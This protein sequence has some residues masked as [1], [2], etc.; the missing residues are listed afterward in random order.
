MDSPKAELKPEYIAKNYR[1]LNADQIGI[2][3]ATP[4]LIPHL[5]SVIPKFNETQMKATIPILSCEQIRTTIPKLQLQQT[6]TAIQVMNPAQ[7]RQTIT[8]LTA[9]DKNL[10]QQNIILLQTST[11]KDELQ[12]FLNFVDPLA[13]AFAIKNP[14]LTKRILEVAAIMTV[15]QLRVVLPLLSDE[16]VMEAFLNL[17]ENQM[18]IA[19]SMIMEKKVSLLEKVAKNFNSLQK[20]KDEIK[21]RL[22]STQDQT[23]H[24]EKRITNLE[25]ADNKDDEYQTIVKSIKTTKTEVEG[26]QKNMRDIQAAFKLPF[27]ILSQEQN[28]DIYEKYHKLS[29]EISQMARN[30]HSFLSRLSSNDGLTSS[31][32][33]IW[34]RVQPPKIRRD[35]STE[36]IP[37]TESESL[38]LDDNLAI[39]LYDAVKQ[40]GNPD[41]IG[42]WY[43]M[44]WNDIISAGFR[45]VQDFREKGVTSLELLQQYINSLKAKA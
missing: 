13:M 30:G 41:A 43:S 42:S 11:N 10:L 18:E 38:F 39:V 21:P 14:D 32:N 20:L 24:L 33:D 15:D 1:K 40:I 29:N 3:L 22:E 19:A 44:T 36:N 34:Q 31:L 37:E 25:I 27:R 17:D 6:G 8:S 26:L 28:P 12:S 16:E 5:L 2:A 23:E 9:D 35:P 45:S 4:E 7:I